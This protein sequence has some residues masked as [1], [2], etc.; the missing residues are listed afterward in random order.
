MSA[1][2]KESGLLGPVSSWHFIPR[3][4]PLAGW[5]HR[6]KSPDLDLKWVLL[7][8]PWRTDGGQGKNKTGQAK[9]TTKRF[10]QVEDDDL[11]KDQLYFVSITEMNTIGFNAE[12][13]ISVR[14]NKIRMTPA[15]KQ[16]CHAE[17]RTE[18][19]IGLGPNKNICKC[20]FCDF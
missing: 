3:Q 10:V 6:K 19:K 15:A 9:R 18:K 8:I 11:T 20:L 5:G 2:V 4:G 12:S 13:H 17:M 7:I 16:C 1:G 14:K